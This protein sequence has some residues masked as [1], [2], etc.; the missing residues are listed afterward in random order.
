MSSGSQNTCI[1]T[2]CYPSLNGDRNI[3]I[4]YHVGNILMSDTTTSNNILIGSYV[5]Q[6][7]NNQHNVIIG[8]FSGNSLTTPSYN[9]TL[10][11]YTLNNVN[12]GGGNTCIGYYSGDAFYGNTNNSIAIGNN[13]ATDS[14]TTCTDCIYIGAYTYPTTNPSNE[15]VLG[16]NL[17]GMGSDT[18]NFFFDITLLHFSPREE[19]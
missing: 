16:S 11:N 1:G 5:G 10:G 4:G 18:T 8:N 6:F 14:R 19:G 15:V 2:V 3:M 17:L 12:I 13:A 9:V 7:I